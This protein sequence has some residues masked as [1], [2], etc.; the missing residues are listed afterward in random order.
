[1]DLRICPVAMCHLD[2]SEQMTVNKK[3]VPGDDGTGKRG[4]AG[5]GDWGRGRTLT[6]GKRGGLLEVAFRYYCRRRGDNS[7]FIASYR[8]RV[9]DRLRF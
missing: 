1:M 9:N 2:C 4:L 8:L 6:S 3:P 7:R 5:D